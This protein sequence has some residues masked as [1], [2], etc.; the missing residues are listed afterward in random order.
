[1]SRCI[2]HKLRK[3]KGGYGLLTRDGKTVYAHRFAWENKHGKIPKGMFVCHSCDNK[4]CV[5]LKHLFL[6]SPKENSQDMLKKGRQHKW[7]GERRGE[8]NPR[9]RL[10]EHDV[11]AIRLYS[12]LGFTNRQLSELFDVSRSAI[13]FAASGRTWG[14][15]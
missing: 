10:Q 1:M 3:S 15:L 4:S 13:N 5:N 2:E 6:G 7:S 8:S 11:L 14:H 9:A 12:S